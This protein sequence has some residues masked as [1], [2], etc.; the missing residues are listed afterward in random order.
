MGAA[1]LI[2]AAADDSPE[3][4]AIKARMRQAFYPDRDDWRAMV[5]ERAADVIRR[6]MRGLAQS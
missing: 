3:G 6:A 5:W 2:S 4:R 1:A